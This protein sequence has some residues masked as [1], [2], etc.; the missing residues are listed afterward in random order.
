MAGFTRR[1]LVELLQSNVYLVF[2][3]TRPIKSLSC[4]PVRDKQVSD[5]LDG[6]PGTMYVYMSVHGSE[7][8]SRVGQMGSKEK[9]AGF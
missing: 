6:Q 4:L 9:N 5:T 7:T 2:Y 1:K 8:G 3:P